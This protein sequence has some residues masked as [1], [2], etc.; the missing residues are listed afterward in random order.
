[1]EQK[2]SRGRAVGRMNETVTAA[3]GLLAGTVSQMRKE[4][5]YTSR[6][7]ERL[8]PPSDDNRRP[9]EKGEKGE[10]ACSW[11]SSSVACAPRRAVTRQIYS[12]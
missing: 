2:R 6:H 11:A 12:T 1:M 3:G 5:I 4:R 7:G 9:G 10:G 8:V